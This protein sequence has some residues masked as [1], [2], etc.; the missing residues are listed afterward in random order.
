MSQRTFKTFYNG[1]I[2]GV[3]KGVELMTPAERRRAALLIVGSVINALLQII[4]LVGLVGVIRF[5]ADSTATPP[6]WLT[7]IIGPFSLATADRKSL[8]VALALT[9]ALLVAI[10]VGFSW[11]HAGALARFSAQ[12]ENRLSSFLMRRT[13]FAPFEWIVGQNPERLRQ[14][15]FGFVATWSR[16]FVRNLMRIANDVI[17]GMF[18]VGLLIWSQPLVGAT[19]AAAGAAV[20]AMIFLIVRPQIRRLAELKRVG[21]LG[22]SSVSQECIHGVK[23]VKMASAEAHFSELFDEQVAIYAGSDAEAQG[24]AQLPRHLLEMLAYGALIA[25]VLFV[26]LMGDTRDNVADALLLYA[27]AALR[28]LPIFSTLVGGLS[29]LASSLPIVYDLHKLID[30][31]ATEEQ[32]QSDSVGTDWRLVRLENVSMSYASTSHSALRDVTLTIEHGKSYGIVGPSGAGKSTLI[33]VLAGLLSPTSGSILIDGT[34]LDHRNRRSWRG[35]FGYVSQRLFLLDASL[36]RNVVF[37]TVGAIDEKRL[38]DALRVACLDTVVERLRGGIEG[39]VGPQGALLSG[40][41]R[42]RVVIARALYR[43]ADI[44]ILDEPTSSLDVIVEHD[45]A[46]AI[47][48]LRGKVTTLLVSHRLGLVRRCDAIWLFE[49]GK[50]IG[51][52]PHDALLAAAA[53][54]R[55]MLE[56]SREM[57]AV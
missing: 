2:G 20:G 26:A 55:R 51:N 17:M 12:C 22:A 18:I 36:K 52:A 5:M 44:L 8:G 15:L 49:D 46:E 6:A 14:H 48:A 27:L 56:Q 29:S 16:E 54:Y 38:S 3:G 13:L 1:L 25:A 53:L 35:R 11:W 32:A 24:W 39:S 40:G 28:L 47:T 37:G 57:N 4:V 9:A 10:K 33:D 7:R 45:I 34:P 30:Q 50:L 31:T 21:I 19:V 43:G 41:E 42:Q 23:D